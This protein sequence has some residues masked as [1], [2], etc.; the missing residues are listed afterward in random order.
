MNFRNVNSRIGYYVNVHPEIFLYS[1]IFKMKQE[2]LLWL[3]LHSKLQ[4]TFIGISVEIFTWRHQRSN[5]KHKND[6]FFCHF[7]KNGF[8]KLIII[9]LGTN[10]DK[11]VNFEWKW[12]SN[13]CFILWK[14]ILIVFNTVILMSLNSNFGWAKFFWNFGGHTN[15]IWTFLAYRNKTLV[16]FSAFL[17]G[18]NFQ[19]HS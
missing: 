4:D 12:L 18:K 14:W 1:K 19:N 5:F 11:N 8:L 16:N 2:N 3:F 15:L 17:T 13:Q 6:P 9:Q 7:R 10:N